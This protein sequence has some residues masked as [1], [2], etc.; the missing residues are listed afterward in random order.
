MLK[1]TYKK[2]LPPPSEIKGHFLKNITLAFV[3]VNSPMFIV[4]APVAF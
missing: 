1:Q 3:A 4:Y 2:T